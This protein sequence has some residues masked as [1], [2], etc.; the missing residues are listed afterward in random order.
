MVNTQD[1]QAEIPVIFF[2]EG[3]KFVAYSPALDLSSCGG[4]LEQAKSRFTEAAAIFLRE[5]GEMGTLDEVLSE[6]GWYRA[7][8]EQGWNPP[9]YLGQLQEK[10]KIPSVS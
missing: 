2:K 7:S 3:D 4:S 8:P 9:V 6:C 5:V 10:V 1:I